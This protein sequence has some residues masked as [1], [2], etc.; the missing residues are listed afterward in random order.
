MGVARV[1]REMYSMQ[2][3]RCCCMD[4]TAS[5]TM[6]R[7]TK[8]LVAT[9][10]GVG[11]QYHSRAAV[12]DACHSQVAA[13]CLMLQFCICICSCMHDARPKR[14]ELAAS[15]LQALSGLSVCWKH[16]AHAAALPAPRAV[17]QH[18]LIV[19]AEKHVQS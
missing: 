6:V 16:A 11:P 14:D 1:A 12:H 9:A 3:C 2:V 19:A 7:Y 13:V 8:Q 15:S 17:V 4:S 18:A 10:W 5:V